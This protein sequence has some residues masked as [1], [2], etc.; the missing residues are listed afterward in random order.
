MPDRPLLHHRGR[1]RQSGPQ[2]NRSAARRP[3]PTGSP[4]HRPIGFVASRPKL[5]ALD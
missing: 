1:R 4:V 2:G 3:T 5:T